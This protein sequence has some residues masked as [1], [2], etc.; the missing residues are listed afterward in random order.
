MALPV[1]CPLTYGSRGSSLGLGMDRVI[2][3]G[4]VGTLHA[5]V[6]RVGLHRGAVFNGCLALCRGMEPV[7]SG[8]PGFQMGG[9]FGDAKAGQAMTLTMWDSMDAAVESRRIEGEVRRRII[10]EEGMAFISG[11]RYEIIGGQ[12]ETIGLGRASLAR[13][14]RVVRAEGLTADGIETGGGVYR[15]WSAE[16]KPAGLCCRYLLADPQSGNATSLSLWASK[17]DQTATLDRAHR[18]KNEFVG[19]VD[20]RVNSVESYEVIGLALGDMSAESENAEVVDLRP[21]PRPVATLQND[22]KNANAPSGLTSK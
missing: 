21:M 13:Y 14:A 17:D 11:L 4:E 6:S 7:L 16:P 2:C 18:R 9:W 8:L 5:R 10:D 19:R 20:C 15:G 1:P 3:A 22:V 12:H